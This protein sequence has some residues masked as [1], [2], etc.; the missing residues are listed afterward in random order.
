M[1]LYA[2]NNGGYVAHAI[3]IAGYAGKFSAWFDINGNLVD[4]ETLLPNG[5]ARKVHPNS[6]ARIELQRI[7]KRYQH[8]PIR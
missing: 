5:Q 2:F 7:G 6:P 4:C 1:Q 3:R 8:T